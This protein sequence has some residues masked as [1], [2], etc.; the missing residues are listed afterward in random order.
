MII[1]VNTVLDGV[2]SA[3]G[4]ISLRQAV[5][6]ANVLTSEDAIVFT[7][8][9]TTPQTITLTNGPLVRT[10]KATTTI[11]G[12]GANLLTVSGGGQSRV[13]D[14]AGGSVAMQDLTIADGSADNGGGLQNNGGTLVMT[15][16]V[17]SGNRA[18]GSGGG[19]QNAAGSATLNSVTFGNNS[20]SDGGGL[21]NAATLSM[22]GGMVT[23][24]TAAPMGVACGTD[25]VPRRSRIPP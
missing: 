18:T 15:D 21:A 2:G 14:I 9:F 17:V 6:L 12:P 5:N 11:A 25:P 4:Q 20:A 10:D 16:A 22:T 8:L 23:G 13:F 7:S 1:P 19:L 3:P 24:N